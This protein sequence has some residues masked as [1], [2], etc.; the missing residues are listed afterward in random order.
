MIT[1][2]R[3]WLICESCGEFFTE[4]QAEEN[5]ICNECENGKLR[6]SCVDCGKVL[7]DCKCGEKN[8]EKDKGKK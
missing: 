1:R 7:Q 5:Q 6:L 2:P 3:I 8:E 4:E